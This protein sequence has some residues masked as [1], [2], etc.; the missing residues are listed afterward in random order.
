MYIDLTEINL[1][2]LRKDLIE[3]YTAAMY[4]VSPIAMM[5]IERV[6]NASD[7]EL[8]QIALNNKINL[9]NYKVK[10]SIYK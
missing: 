5:D 8:V 4:M 6:K 3:H 1:E 2:K 9:N 10:R 7:E